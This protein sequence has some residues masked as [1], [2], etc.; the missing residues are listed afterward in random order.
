MNT[1]RQCFRI[2]HLHGVGATIAI[3]IPSLRLCH[4][5]GVTKTTHA[6]SALAELLFCNA[7]AMTE[8][9]VNP[10]MCQ[11]ADWTKTRLCKKTW[12][13]R[14][15]V[16]L[17]DGSLMVHGAIKCQITTFLTTVTQR[18]KCLV[19]AGHSSRG[20]V[21]QMSHLMKQDNQH[22]YGGYDQDRHSAVTTCGSH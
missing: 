22:V 13:W 9:R 5:I 21:L 20:P 3:A 10:C 1:F 14:E 19:F 12:L 15:T 16:L 18:W 2:K 8:M 7:A 6:I 4:E 11:P 17:T